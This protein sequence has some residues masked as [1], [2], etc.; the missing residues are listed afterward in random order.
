MTFRL[1]FSSL[2]SLANPPSISSSSSSTRVH[3]NS[4][5]FKLPSRFR[6][7]SADRRRS[8]QIAATL[9]VD[10]Q[11]SGEKNLDTDRPRVL[12]EVKDLTAIVAESRQEILRGVNLTINEG[13]VLVGHPDYEVTGGTVSF[14]GEDLLNMEPETRS[15][16]GLFMS[17]QTPVEIPGV[18][19]MDFLLMACNARREKRGEPTLSPIEF[20]GFLSPKLAAVNMNPRFL[21][22][23]VNEGFSG[24]EKKRN[25]IL[26]LAEILGIKYFLCVSSENLL[27]KC[28]PAQENSEKQRKSGEK[29]REN[30][31]AFK[32]SLPKIFPGPRRLRFARSVPPAARGSVA[33]RHGLVQEI[34][35][36]YKCFLSNWYHSTSIEGERM[37]GRKVKVLEGELGQLKADFEPTTCRPPYPLSPLAGSLHCRHP[38]V[39]RCRRPWPADHRPLPLADHRCWLPSITSGRRYPLAATATVHLRLSLDTI[40][41]NWP[42]PLV[43]EAELAILDEIDSGLDVDALQDVA[44]AVNGLLKP[45]NSILMITHYQ[46]LLDY[47]KPNYVHIMLNIEVKEKLF[48]V[49]TG[50]REPSGFLCAYSKSTAA[51]VDRENTGRFSPPEA[52]AIV[53]TGD[54]SLAKQLEKEGYRAISSA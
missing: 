50:Q 17:F 19:N 10:S 41:H 25:E 35:E 29:L 38:A 51:A 26:Q 4:I 23:N 34:H 33:S 52:G 37:A 18:S 12:L 3:P 44:K 28:C 24:G 46:R 32:I 1:C 53:R 21:D 5:S 45:H 15:H 2:T 7:R 6:S 40:D 22:R 49:D 31:F 42:P 43:L 39:G 54:F 13:E 8:Y 27:A 11:T 16:A 47:I 9:T 48:C 36:I 20:F 14:K 30:P